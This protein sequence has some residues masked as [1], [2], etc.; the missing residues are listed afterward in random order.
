[1]RSESAVTDWSVMGWLSKTTE[2]F[3]L[4]TPSRYGQA[5]PLAWR[6]T[7]Q[8]MPARTSSRRSSCGAPPQSSRSGMTQ[9][10][11]AVGPAKLS[12]AAWCAPRR[13]LMCSSG[14]SGDTSSDG[15]S[16]PCVANCACIDMGGLAAPE[17]ETLVGSA[18]GRAERATRTRPWPLF[19]PVT[20]LHVF[21]TNFSL[22]RCEHLLRPH[23]RTMRGACEPCEFTVYKSVG[24][25][26][27]VGTSGPQESGTS[28]GVLFGALDGR[29]EGPAQ[30]GEG[31]G[32]PT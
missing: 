17:R 14:G 10:L 30:R 19:G 27:A 20:P 2:A 28:E 8:E 6:L 5:S 7:K 16:S 25:E 18:V 4:S 3:N 22:R 12:L 21:P 1:M 23:V 31:G 29:P 26:P 11:R 32:K 15:S 9:L 13:E 24:T